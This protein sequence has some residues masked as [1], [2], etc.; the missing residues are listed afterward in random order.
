MRWLS[1]LVA[2]AA[3]GGSGAGGGDDDDAPPLDAGDGAYRIDKVGT[4]NL[5]EGGFLGVYASLQDGPEL[6][7]PTSVANDDECVVYRRP[8]PALCDPACS[9]GVCTA[10]NTCTPFA[11]N[12]SA[13]RITVG[14]LRAPLAFAPG[15][16]GYVPEPAPSDDLFDPGAAITVSAP[17][18]VTPAFS[19]SLTAPAPLAAPFQNLTL[20]DGDDATIT[21]T[22]AGGGARS[23]QV[24]L[25]VGWH[26]APPEAMMI[27]E[28]DD[29]GSLT[30]PGALVSAL[31]RAS[32][33]LESHPSW[34]LRFD[35]AV[36]AAPAGPVEIVAGS[37]VS[38]YFA[39]P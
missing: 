29:D 15:A 14:G 2:L 34:I 37:Q 7:T 30:I 12:A 26:G 16:F 36:V 24:A 17:G 5:I 13:G 31:P 32:S 8:A 28:T 33:S 1:I 11:Q 22:P 23:I 21:W 9:N 35:R 3:C 19:V 38:L 4:I 27:C 39:H 25:V 10:A 6:P 18:D 20:R